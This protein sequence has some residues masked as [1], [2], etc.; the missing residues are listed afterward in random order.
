M[1]FQVAV[2]PVAEHGGF[3]ASMPRPR[4]RSHTF[5]ECSARGRDL[6]L[7]YDFARRR[8]HAVGDDLLVNV[9]SHK[10]GLHRSKLHNRVFWGGGPPLSIVEDPPLPTHSN[11]EGAFSTNDRASSFPSV[12]P[13]VPP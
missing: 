1:R 5:I 2:D 8:L 4:Q 10:I 12:P 3:H 13:P 9:E 7:R 6:A 11:S